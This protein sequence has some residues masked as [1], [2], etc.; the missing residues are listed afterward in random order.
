[1][2]FVSLKGNRT[3]ATSGAGTL[4]PS[5]SPNQPLVLWRVC[6]A[7]SLV[8]CVVFCR[9]LFVLLGFFFFWPLYCLS[10]VELRFWVTLWHLPTFLKRKWPSIL[11]WKGNRRTRE[12]YR[13]AASHWQNLSHNVYRVH[14][15]ASWNETPNFCGVR[16]WSYSST[17]HLLE[18]MTNETKATLYNLNIIF[19]FWDICCHLYKTFVQ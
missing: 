11:L 14:I 19:D 1:M 10:F 2:R 6:N 18:D 12:K 3:G 9:L 16:Q 7:Q 8:F 5:G 15:V 4:Y 17:Y 13:P